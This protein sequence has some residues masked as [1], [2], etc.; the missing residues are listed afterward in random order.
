MGF[1]AICLFFF[2]FSTIIGWNLFGRINV[3]YLFGKKADLLLLHP[4]HCLHLPGVP[5]LQRAGLGAD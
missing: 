1:V 4:G 2:A 5:A 3:H